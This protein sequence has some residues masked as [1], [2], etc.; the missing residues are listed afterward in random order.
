MQ[1]SWPFHT[2]FLCGIIVTLFN[3][4]ITTHKYTHLHTLHSQYG[5]VLHTLDTMHTVAKGEVISWKGICQDCGTKLQNPRHVSEVSLPGL[6]ASHPL[7][8]HLQLVYSALP[9][10][11]SSVTR[12]ACSGSTPIASEYVCEWCSIVEF[13]KLCLMCCPGPYCKREPMNGDFSVSGES[14]PNGKGE[15]S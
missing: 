6:W 3:K 2:L 11:H 14:K 9:Q 4:Y 1:I 7:L 15:C 10:Q 5:W 13:I 8:F 12:C